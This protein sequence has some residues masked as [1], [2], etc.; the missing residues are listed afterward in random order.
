MK[1]QEKKQIS[2]RRTPEQIF[3][4]SLFGY[5]DSVKKLN[6][7]ICQ[8]NDKITEIGK[9]AKKVE[10]SLERLRNIK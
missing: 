4:D 2:P 8:L 5:L 3:E 10:D 9:N 6:S 7:V 1:K